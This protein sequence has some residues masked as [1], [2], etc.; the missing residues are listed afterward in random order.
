MQINFEDYWQENKLFFEKIVLNLS[1]AMKLSS[2]YEHE[3][4]IEDFEKEF[5]KYNK[6][7]YVIAVNSGTT[8]LE[9]SLGACGVKEGDEVIIPSY[10]YIAT[11]LAVSNTGAKPVFVDIKEDTLT[12]DPDRIRKSLTKKTKAV[13]AVHIHGNPCDMEGFTKIA[14]KYGLAIIEDA[15]HAHGAEYRGTKV[16]NFGIGCFSN[17]TTK[18]FSGIGNSGLISTN[19]VRTYE[20]IKKMIEVKN[21]PHPEISKRT[22]CRIDILQA[23]V[24]KTKLPYLGE[25][26]KKRRYNA[27]M[28]IKKLPKSLLFQK[29]EMESRHAYR[30]F[31]VL[32]KNR[33][34]LRSNLE[35]AGIETKVRYTVPL[36]LTEYYKRP[37][38]KKVDLPVTE[39]IF[40]K[41]L[42]LPISHALSEEQIDYIADKICEFAR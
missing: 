10:T 39:K 28:Y 36:H 11:A 24:L 14:K 15:A 34:E 35:R 1:S 22:P 29:V 41:L 6:S 31:V 37:G 33:E 17:H 26:N 38:F 19:D 23:V 7:K 32:S 20:R 3:R 27:A 21:D 40:N 30:D 18:N 25:I 12:M 42:W 2:E 5:A 9:L 8:A 13:V 4:Y 16:G